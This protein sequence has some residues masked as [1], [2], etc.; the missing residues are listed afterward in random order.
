MNHPG[1]I[2]CVAGLFTDEAGE[3]LTVNTPRRG[4]K[5]AGGQVEQEEDP[6]AVEAA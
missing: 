4:W 2:V 3:A 1:H 5:F 6:P